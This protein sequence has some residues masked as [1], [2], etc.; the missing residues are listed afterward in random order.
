LTEPLAGTAR[1]ALGDGW[2]DA[3][4]ALATDDDGW[5]VAGSRVVGWDVGAC[6]VEVWNA[7]VWDFG[8]RDVDFCGVGFWETG[9]WD[10]AFKAVV[11]RSTTEP[12]ASLV[13]E[14]ALFVDFERAVV[15]AGAGLTVT[16]GEVL[17]T[18]PRAFTA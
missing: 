15:A 11:T 3:L 12:L 10:V 16:T 6:D 2:A 4:G 8:F 7:E 13:M 17:V 5:G 18:R 14:P 9:F 1:A